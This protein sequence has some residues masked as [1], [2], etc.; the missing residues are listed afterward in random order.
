MS[1]YVMRMRIT[2]SSPN[3]DLVLLAWKLVRLLTL[4][5]VNLVM[6]SSKLTLDKP[7]L[8]PSLRG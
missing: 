7:T 1:R 8:R 6:Q 4:S 3:S 5:V 2:R